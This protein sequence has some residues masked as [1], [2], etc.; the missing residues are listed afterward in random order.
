M[1]KRRKKIV[2]VESLEVL[3]VNNQNIVKA[4]KGRQTMKQQKKSNTK[5]VG[6]ISEHDEVLVA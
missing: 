6:K 5:K 4:W 1:T 3:E 2:N